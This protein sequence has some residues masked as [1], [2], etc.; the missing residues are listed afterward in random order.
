MDH[1][2]RKQRALALADEAGRREAHEAGAFA[3]EAVRQDYGNDFIGARDPAQ[4]AYGEAWIAKYNELR[5]FFEVA[6]VALFTAYDTQKHPAAALADAA[7]DTLAPQHATID[8]LIAGAA[9]ATL[10]NFIVRRRANSS[11]VRKHRS[12]LATMKTNSCCNEK[13]LK[14][15]IR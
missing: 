5:E 7:L 13:V 3:A 9:R 6:T 10:V 11:A 15:G 2:A 12:A 1:D 8:T 14:M 4:V